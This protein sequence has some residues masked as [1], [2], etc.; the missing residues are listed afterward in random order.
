MKSVTIYCRRTDH[1]CFEDVFVCAGVEQPCEGCAPFLDNVRENSDWK[2]FYGKYWMAS[3]GI[4]KEQ[5]NE[6]LDRVNKD[7]RV[8]KLKIIHS[9]VTDPFK[10]FMTKAMK[11]L[12][13]AIVKNHQRKIDEGK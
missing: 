2:P 6:I 8:E 13:D 9:P 1:T 12:D 11:P 5:Q 7:M 4:S 3:K 10:E